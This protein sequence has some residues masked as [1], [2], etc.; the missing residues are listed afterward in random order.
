MS[1]ADQ[2]ASKRATWSRKTL[3][4]EELQSP[5]SV[6]VIVELMSHSVASPKFGQLWEDLRHLLMQHHFGRGCDLK[7]RNI[8]PS[9]REEL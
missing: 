5:E 4:R 6:I 9:H 1:D 2:G 7:R 8:F 3:Q